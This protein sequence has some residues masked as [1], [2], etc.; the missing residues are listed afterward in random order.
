MDEEMV[1]RLK[2]VA[3]K[4]WPDVFV[5]AKPDLRIVR[6]VRNVKEPAHVTDNGDVPAD[7]NPREF[8][9]KYG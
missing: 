9:R 1:C 7:Y 3:R 6:N 8:R 5:G 4:M 2:A